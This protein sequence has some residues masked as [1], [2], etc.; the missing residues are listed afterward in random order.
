MSH[1]GMGLANA[2]LWDEAGHRSI[3]AV[4]AVRIFHVVSACRRW[5]LM[6]QSTF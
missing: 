5:I 6:Q 1:A 4:L 3:E 2:W